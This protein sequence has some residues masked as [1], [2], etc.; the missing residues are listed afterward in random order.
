MTRFIKRSIVVYSLLFIAITVFAQTESGDD[1]RALRKKARQEKKEAERMEMYKRAMS[2]K[3]M[4]E[5]RKFVLETE[6]LQPYDGSPEPVDPS[7]NFIY[8][9]SAK[10]AIQ[11]NAVYTLGGSS[12]YGTIAEGEIKEYI[13]KGKGE[14]A[15]RYTVEFNVSTSTGIL[16]I[17]IIVSADGKATA[18]VRTPSV[19]GKMIYS[20]RL[21]SHSS[22]IIQ[23]GFSWD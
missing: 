23:K 6:F 20:G 17:S 12:M 18:S 22:S 11:L 14:K 5:D 10:C 2:I 7:R 9:D 21:V 8:V 3:K 13:I 15:I 19:S 16:D 1:R 4:L